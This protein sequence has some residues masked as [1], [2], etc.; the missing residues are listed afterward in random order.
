MGK[1][2]TRLTTW[3]TIETKNM[4]KTTIKPILKD[5]QGLGIS[6]KQGLRE[7]YIKDL[8]AKYWPENELLLPVPEKERNV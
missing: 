6:Y 7:E 8:H 5:T 2:F 4:K 1:K 3:E